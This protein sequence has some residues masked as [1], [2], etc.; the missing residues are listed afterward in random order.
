MNIPSL[1]HRDLIFIKGKDLMQLLIFMNIVLG[2][3]D[4]SNALK[5]VVEL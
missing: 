3:T 5:F 2:S 4:F 1:F